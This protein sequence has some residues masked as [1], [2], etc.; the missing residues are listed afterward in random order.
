MVA[1]DNFLMKFNGEFGGEE[2]S[3]FGCDFCSLVATLRV[4]FQLGEGEEAYFTVFG[5]I[6]EGGKIEDTWQKG[7]DDDGAL[8]FEVP[9]D[10][11][12]VSLRGTV[13]L[14]LQLSSSGARELRFEK[15]GGCGEVFFEKGEGFFRLSEGIGG[16][17][18]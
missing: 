13:L 10:P 15:V 8:L 1:C 16:V 18:R 12:V 11:R 6:V 4:C 17:M 9:F 7:F 14:E 3:N 2:I 5:E